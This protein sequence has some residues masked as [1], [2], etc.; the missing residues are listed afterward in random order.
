MLFRSIRKWH[1]KG[2][3]DG[4]INYMF[5]KDWTHLMPVAIENLQKFDI[6]RKESFLNT[7]PEWTELM[8]EYGYNKD[9]WKSNSNV[10]YVK[11][12][13]EYNLNEY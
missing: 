7:F 10:A 13:R 9:N 12:Y 8:A 5:S 6:R 4:M 1:D 3:V 2:D 11:D